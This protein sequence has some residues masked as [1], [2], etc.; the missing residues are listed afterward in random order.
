MQGKNKLEIED[1]KEFFIPVLIVSRVY[2]LYLND[3]WHIVFVLD[4]VCAVSHS[5]LEAKCIEVITGNV[6]VVNEWDICKEPYTQTT[7]AK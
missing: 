3:S 2:F 4:F 5:S 7:H 6:L 1:M